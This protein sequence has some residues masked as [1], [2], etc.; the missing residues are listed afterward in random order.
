MLVAFT[1]LAAVN[2]RRFLYYYRD[3]SAFGIKGR[4]IIS[5]FRA[6]DI[7]L[8]N[9][10]KILNDPE[11]IIEEAEPSTVPFILLLRLQGMPGSTFVTLQKS[12]NIRE[13]LKKAK[14]RVSPTN[15][16]VRALLTKV[17]KALDIKNA[18]IAGLKA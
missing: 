12:Y 9:L 1:D 7:W 8:Y 16:T 14:Q 11:A 15:R 3:T 13:A 10:F 17:G 18:E 4:N 2:K 6:T 5:G